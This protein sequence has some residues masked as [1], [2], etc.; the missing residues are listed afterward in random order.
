MTRSAS[1]AAPPLSV[2]LPVRNGAQFLEEALAS[3]EGQTFPDFQV[4]A[5]DDGSTDGTREILQEAAGRDRR[6]QVLTQDPKGIVAALELA[7]WSARGLY[8]ARMDAD[9][10]ALPE[11][12]GRQMDLMTTDR[13]I[14]ACG[15]CVTYFPPEKV[16]EGAR[17]Y[18]AWINELTTHEAME[19][20]LFVECPLPHP[21]LLLRADA[22]EVAGGYRDL[23]W[24]EDYDLVFRLWEGGGRFAKVPEVL[25][26]WRE[27]EERLS[28][29]QGAYSEESFRRCKV[30]FLQRFHLCGGKGVVVWGA[31]PVGKAFAR[32]LLRQGGT[33]V[34]FVDVDPRKVGQRVHGVPVISPEDVDRVR[35][36]FC[37]AAV[38]QEGARQE[39]RE[40]LGAAGWMELRDFVAV[41]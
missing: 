4:L 32:E 7:R 18:E 11:R 38:G 31:G 12:F 33:L 20:D 19:R 22:V 3:L 14:V 36:S 5:V 6:F 35:G 40:T 28:R 25:L 9:D 1:A 26:R 21:T 15:T 41:A 24:P 17:R 13:R 10:L 37:V 16:R 34:A 27:G 2:L 23:G 30:H 8:L 39:I 29:T